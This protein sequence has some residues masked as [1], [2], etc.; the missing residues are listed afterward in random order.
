MAGLGKSDTVT[1]LLTTPP[2]LIGTILVLLNA[3]H[4]DKTGERYL[5]LALPPILAVVCF[6]LAVATT[7]FAPRYV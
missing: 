6:I 2:Y 5:H 1:L 4:A 7:S 3:W